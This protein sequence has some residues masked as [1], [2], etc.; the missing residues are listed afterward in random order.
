MR[1]AWLLTLA[2]GLTSSTPDSKSKCTRLNF[3]IHSMIRSHKSART[4]TV[5]TLMEELMMDGRNESM[6]EKGIGQK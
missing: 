3:Y 4:K 5:D 1:T 6:E 2:V